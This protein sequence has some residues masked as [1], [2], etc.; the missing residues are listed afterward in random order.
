[1]VSNH[2]VDMKHLT[3]LSATKNCIELHR[4]EKLQDK[5]RNSKEMM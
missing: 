5:K 3:R 4:R 1:M 2:S